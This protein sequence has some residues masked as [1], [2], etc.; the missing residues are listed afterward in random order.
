MKPAG[1]RVRRA[2]LLALGGWVL[3]SILLGEALLHPERAPAPVGTAFPE[4]DVEVLGSLVDGVWI[5]GWVVAPN[6][7]SALGTV[8]LLHGSGGVRRVSDHRALLDRGWRVVSLDFRGHGASGDALTGFGWAERAEVEYAL[9]LAERRW[10]DQPIVGWGRSLGAAALLHA[11][12]ERRAEGDARAP[13][14]LVLEACYADLDAAFANRLRVHFGPLGWPP[15][16]GLTR[17]WV[18]WRAALPNDRLR[19]IDRLPPTGATAL[20]LA[21]GALDEHLSAAEWD[22]WRH[23]LPDATAVLVP[24]RGHEPLSGAPAF[25]AALDE[26][27]GALAEPPGS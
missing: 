9:S 11:L 8:V 21:R 7:G 16:F 3:A 18:G 17:A 22:A 15:L 2:L 25:D 10:S 13:D 27:L 6:D 12:A 19:P 1:R 5:E 4:H 24:E 14:A 23:A 20:L 26:L